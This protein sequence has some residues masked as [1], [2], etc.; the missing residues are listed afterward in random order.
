MKLLE[1]NI[2]S[3]V[4]NIIV[5]NIFWNFQARTAKTKINKWDY[6]KLKSFAQKRKTSTKWKGNLLN[7]RDIFR[8]IL[9]KGLIAKMYKEFIKCVFKKQFDFKMDQGHFVR[10]KK[11]V[12]MESGLTVCW[13]CMLMLPYRERGLLAIRYSSLWSAQISSPT[14][15]LGK[16]LA[17][18]SKVVSMKDLGYILP[19]NSS[20]PRPPSRNS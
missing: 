8:N 4:L 14:I 17:L 13:F 19:R 12:H 15:H 5:S 10:K 7:E 18:P 16:Y 1:E 2:H 11:K 6:I 20:F 3:K 9:Y